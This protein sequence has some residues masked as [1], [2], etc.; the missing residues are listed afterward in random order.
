MSS[1]CINQNLEMMPKN[2]GRVFVFNKATK[3]TYSLGCNEYNVLRILDGIKTMEEIHKQFNNYSLY[4]IENLINQFSK[5][6]LLNTEE[7]KQSPIDNEANKKTENIKDKKNKQLSIKDKKIFK[8]FSLKKGILHPDNSLDKDKRIFRILYFSITYLSLPIFLTG[9]FILIGTSSVNASLS[10]PPWYL[11]IPVFLISIS[12]HE[13]A[14]IIVAKNNGAHI[15]EIGLRLILIVP[16]IYSSIVG[17]S[18]I[19]SKMK[20]ILISAAGILLNLQVA[21][22][23]FILTAFTSGNTYNFFLWLSMLNLMLVMLN[24]IFLLKF[25]GY[26]ILAEL[27]NDKKLKENSLS[28]LSYLVFGKIFRKTATTNI[29]IKLSLNKKIIY[30]LYG[31]LNIAFVGCIF[32]TF[33]MNIIRFISSKI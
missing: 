18:Y 20:R 6:G 9:L 7:T 30:V 24:L 23:G 28:Y 25:D 32:V 2:D 27:L 4:D 33:I 3:K 22:I 11:F 21:G 19:E 29:K 8:I 31:T 15:A 10:S 26:Y 1:P 17:I 14:H 12:L 5:I 13:F 16:C